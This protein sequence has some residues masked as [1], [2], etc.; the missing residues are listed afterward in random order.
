MLSKITLPLA[1]MSIVITL[2]QAQA[3]QHVPGA[4]PPFNGLVWDP[5]TQGSVAPDGAIR[6]SPSHRSRSFQRPPQPF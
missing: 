2:T 1:L 6:P 4:P 5:P 3:Q